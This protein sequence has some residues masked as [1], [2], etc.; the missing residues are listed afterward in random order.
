[1]NSINSSLFSPHFSFE[2]DHHSPLSKQNFGYTDNNGGILRANNNHIQDSTIPIAMPIPIP[3]SMSLSMPPFHHPP[4]QPLPISN[5]QYFHSNPY[6]IYT[7]NSPLLYPNQSPLSTTT[8]AT[9]NTNINNSFEN[10]RNYSLPSFSP[11]HHQQFQ[12]QQHQQQQPILNRHM[13]APA[14]PTNNGHGNLKLKINPTPLTSN[15]RK[16]S[17]HSAKGKSIINNNNGYKRHRKK[18]NEIER[19]YK[20]NYENCDKAY[21]TLNHLNTHITIQGH[22]KKRSPN[23]FSELRKLLKQKRINSNSNSSSSSNSSSNLISTANNKKQIDTFQFHFFHS[24]LSTS[25]AGSGTII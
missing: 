9:S 8:S 14:C 20:C 24:D 25:A 11:L 2:F 7:T 18:F 12:Q 19:Y 21:G 23:E 16:G 22:G 3:V 10:R 13:S 5:Q 1:M 15:S 17:S 4:Q 6:N